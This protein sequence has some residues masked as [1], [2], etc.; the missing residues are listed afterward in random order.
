MK[1]NVIIFSASTG[2]GHNQ[3]AFTLEHELE[4]QGFVVKVVEP[5][6]ETS[7]IL[8][9]CVSDGYKI[10]AT[11]A[12]RMFGRLYKMSNKSYINK[13]ISRYTRHKIE[14]KLGELLVRHETDMVICTHPL[15]VKAISYMKHVGKFDGQIISVI[16]DYLPHECYVSQDVD[17]YIVGSRYTKS[18]LVHRGIQ[19]RKIH[20]HGIPI[21]R[22]F[23]VRHLNLQRSERFT[24]LLMGG[25][26]G[27][28]GMKK[29]Y[30]RL[31]ALEEPMKVFVV[32][33][34]N[35][36]MRES[37]SHYDTGIHQVE[38]L[39]FTDRVPELMEISDVIVSKPG[40]LT[41]TESLAKEI[42]M[43]IPYCIPGQEQENTDVLVDAGAAI[44]VDGSRALVSTINELIHNPIQLDIL[45]RNMKKIAKDHSLDNAVDLCVEVYSNYSEVE[46]VRNA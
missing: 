2:H 7:P 25:S 16:T 22:E 17:A 37:L 6:K 13:P 18:A 30:K 15:F 19:A 44:K 41:V 35:K 38:I 42:P 5:F 8:D 14:S 39:G 4:Q 12:P 11:R 36:S 10:L 27:V 45:R 21:K 33:G 43:I 3:V 28:S 23:A 26:M 40:G 24:I 20:V 34:N 29:S 9:E 46:G 31:M 1:G 32:C